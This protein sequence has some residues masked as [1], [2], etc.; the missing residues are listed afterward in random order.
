M[1]I[2]I[3]YTLH[4]IREGE[5]LDMVKNQLTFRLFG[6]PRTPVRK[7]YLSGRIHLYPFPGS[8]IFWDVTTYLR[9]QKELSV[10]TQI[11][12]LNVCKRSE[13]VG[14]LR[15]PQ[16]GW[17]CEP[18]ESIPLDCLSVPSGI[19]QPIEE[20]RQARLRIPST[21]FARRRSSSSLAWYRSSIGHIH[22]DL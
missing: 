17:M 21:R 15:V 12:L 10:D 22:S 9:L 13:R 3:G 4:A 11:P 18:R 8:L 7:G 20:D 5:S 16:S 2:H 1:R 6:T 14:E 19:R